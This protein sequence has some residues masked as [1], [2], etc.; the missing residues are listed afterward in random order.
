MSLENNHFWSFTP[1]EA[2]DYEICI[3]A[4]NC[5]CNSG[6]GDPYMQ[7]AVWQLDGPAGNLDQGTKVTD[8]I[9]TVGNNTDLCCGNTICDTISVSAG[10]DVLI[11]LDGNA[12]SECDIDMTV[13]TVPGTGCGECSLGCG[14]NP[15]FSVNDTG[16]C[17]NSESFDFTNQGSTGANWNFEWDV[18][19]DGI[20]DY[21]SE[22]VTGH[23]Y[24]SAGTYTVKHVV[25]SAGI[26]MDST[27]LDVTVGQATATVAAADTLTCIRTQ[28]TLDASGSTSTPGSPTFSWS[29][30]DGNIVSGANTDSPIVDDAGT[31]FVTVTDDSLGCTNVDSVTVP[32][33]TASPA[34][35]IVG[36]DQITCSKTTDT[37]DGTG[38]T[39]NSGSINYSWSTTDG[40]IINNLTDSVVVDEAGTYQLVVTDPDNGCTDTTTSTVGI[41]TASPTAS[42]TGVDILHCNKATDTLDGTGSTTNSGNI[43]YSWSTSDGSILNNLTDSIIVDDT[44]TYQLVVTNPVNGCTD[45]TSVTLDKDDSLNVFVDRIRDDLCRPGAVFIDVNGGT[46]PYTYN[47]SDGSTD[48]N[49][50]GVGAGTYT[51]T[52]TDKYGCQDTTSGTVNEPD[53]LIA[54]VDSVTHV[55][56]HSDTAGE[57]FIDVS[58]GKMPYTYSWS[59]GSTDSN[60]TN[61]GAG[62]YGVTITDDNGCQDSTNMTTITEP[63]TLITSVDSITHV[64]CHGD[65]TGDIFIDVTG[66]VAPYT[67][68]WS[69]GATDSNLTDVAAGTYTVT[70]TDDN[71]CT[72]TTSATV[73]EPDSLQVT[74]DSIAHILC[75]TTGDIHIDVFGGVAPYSFNWSDGSTDSN[76]TDASQGTYTVTIT[77]AN[78]CTDTTSGTIDELDSLIVTI[79]SVTH[80]A[81]NGD[82]IGE[83]F[84]DVTGGELP[85]NFTWSNGST[86]SNLTG[87][88]AGTY[89][90]TVTENNTCTDTASATITEPTPITLSADSQQSTCGNND[91]KAWVTVSG[92]VSPY[93]Y[94]WDD[95]A[96]QTTDTAF[97]LGAGVY[98]VTVTDDNG[99]IDSVSVT[100][101]DAGAPTVTLDSLFNIKCAGDSSGSIYI[102]VSGGTTPYDYN[103]SNGDT[104]QDITGLGPG[105]YDLQLTD[106]VGCIVNKSY[107]VTSPDPLTLTID[108]TNNIE[109]AADNDGAIYISVNQG[110]TPYS[111]NWSN[112]DTT[113]DLTNISGGNYSVTVTDSN[114]CVLTAD[115]SISEPSALTTDLTVS[116]ETCQGA[117]DGAIN[118][119]V[120]GGT[121]SYSYQWSNGDT[122]QDLTDIG[123]GTYSVTITDSNGCLIS[124]TG[125]VNTTTVQAQAEPDSIICEGDS[126]QLQATGGQNYQWQPNIG[127]SDANQPDPIAFPTSS[128]TYYVTVTT[129]SCSDQDSVQI[130][131]QPEPVL[132]T[133]ND[134]TI[135]EGSAADIWAKGADFYNWSPGSSL[136]DSTSDNPAAFPNSTTTYE[137]IGMDTVGCADSDS[138]RVS[139]IPVEEDTLFIPSAFSPNGDGKND[140]WEISNIDNYP[141]NVVKIFNRW[142]DKL[143]EA[144]NYQNDWDGTYQGKAL[145]HGVYFYVLDLKNG[146]E[147]I[148]GTITLIR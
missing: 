12:G 76:L 104:I 106:S 116:D 77:D 126:I 83:I 109:C 52:V 56:C 88:P 92:G 6:G 73:N 122:T 131:V 18:D 148:K 26:C 41:D 143:Y 46:W 98:T 136:S 124:D 111:Y 23:T 65:S 48:S 29:T 117:S 129:D 69:N 72:D 141:G 134:T 85:Y 144:K 132:T 5:C 45:T 38:S 142:G 60:L 59:D 121:P 145:P 120:S 49:L 64:K 78:N 4:Q 97:N 3:T 115:T 57:I 19:N 15:L 96:N 147:P 35:S 75:E 47:W 34:A 27:T 71:G 17:L 44:G 50:T 84:T 138:V 89:S 112:G 66:G 30:S 81:C 140:K 101:N 9:T 107:T 100:V 32:I 14:A 16:Q 130:N 128:T 40:N 91:G 123:P 33:D 146:Q 103:W 13:D 139:V 8:Y 25:D 79:D 90:V 67:F 36:A 55:E 39:T 99:C 7:Y 61:V 93:S 28:D 51:V 20:V 105:T 53:S 118:L 63:D 70:V 37:L 133:S 127:L 22:N 119:T 95:P 135:E 74:V 31:Y 108:S 11:M 2:C 21:T 1:S 94:Q 125:T 24:G 86:D 137:V 62:T 80:V 10:G 87:V 54:L 42:I 110:T 102:S 114:G 68:N 82:S 58:G 43:N 113:Q